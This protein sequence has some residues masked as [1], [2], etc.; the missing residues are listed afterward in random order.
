MECRDC[1]LA[2]HLYLNEPSTTRS[3]RVVFIFGGESL[4]KV[5]FDHYIVAGSSSILVAD[6][7]VEGP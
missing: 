1:R 6:A 2:L 5:I 4:R 7:L 3:I